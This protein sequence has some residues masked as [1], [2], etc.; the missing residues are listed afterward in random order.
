MSF[1]FG[2]SR[3]L[4]WFMVTWLP[5]LL[6][7]ATCLAIEFET[8]IAPII[9]RRC[10]ECHNGRSAK[11]DLDLTTRDGW[12]SGGSSGPAVVEGN[13]ADSYL[14]HRLA[15]GEMPPPVGGV[16]RRLPPNEIAQIRDWVTEGLSWPAGRRL[17]LYEHSTE[18][19]GGRDWWSLQP[20]VRPSVPRVAD[21]KLHEI[22]AFIVDKLVEQGMR[23]AACATPRELIR[24]LY[25]G[26]TGLPPS[27][28]DLALHLATWDDETS[29][30]RLVDQ[31]LQSPRFGERWA[32]YWLDV[33]R[34][35]E[36]CGYERDQLK[37]KIW[38]YRDWVINAL[39]QDMPFDQF[40]TWQLAGDEIEQRSE[41]SLVAT[42]MIRAGTWNDEP[43]D[44]ADYVYERLADMV[45]TT[46]S[47]FLGL[48]VQCARCHDHKFDPIPQEDYYRW[49]SIFWSGYIGQA[50]LGGPSA[51]ELKSDV[52]GWTDRGPDAEPLHLLINGDRH[53]PGRVVAPGT[54][55]AV[56]PSNMSID[57]P[58]PGVSTTQRRL[59]MAR[60]IT[61]PENPLTPRVQVN[62]IWQNL[63]GV[64]LVGTPNNF[65]F[66]GAPPTHPQLL[67]WLAAEYVDNG[68]STKYLI[69]KIVL[70]DTYRQSSNHVLYDDNTNRDAGNRLWWRFLRRRLDAET[71]RDS[72][73][74]VSGDLNLRMGGESFFPKMS[75]EAL[76][77]LSK[78]GDAWEESAQ[79][80]R[81]RRSIYMMT[82]RS[83]ILPFMTT[84]D[85]C[86]T[87]L[88]C[89][90]RDTTTVPTQ[91]LAML[92]NQFVHDRS[93]SLALRIAQ[94]VDGLDQQIIEAFRHV[95]ARDPSDVEL[96]EGRRHVAQQ[97]SAQ[98][99]VVATERDTA[100][101]VRGLGSLCHVLMNSNEFFYVD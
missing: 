78:K 36:T 3:S 39:N 71:V 70:S 26:L 30:P 89:G 16:V 56:L 80:D 40:V 72:L 24:R 76:E 95:L 2:A 22:D 14:L 99:T 43:N 92:N 11:G 90:R 32:R 5:S 48:T 8:E 6:F 23:P 100:P 64:G 20:V 58:R 50:N 18:D 46:S 101:S 74:A 1:S 52:F 62:R 51:D 81:R 55:S 38:M 35:A 29:Y 65:G 88:S 61:D 84:F 42:G 47:A 63:F 85:F 17:D 77:G 33:V 75:A 96:D 54:L 49:A 91:A 60:W 93:Q 37:P 19:R 98:K 73:L 28:D 59:Q 25:Y 66:K 4:D 15:E 53:H 31:L 83:R 57:P 34:F 45:H 44:P 67:D 79:A 12:L 10:V 82:K 7:G 97:V 13:V 68:W 27:A 21:S 41:A 94:S 87:T 86:D 9:V 69:R